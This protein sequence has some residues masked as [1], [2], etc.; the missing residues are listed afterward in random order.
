M[1]LS[2]SG[3]EQNVLGFTLCHIGMYTYTK[4]PNMEYNQGQVLPN[5]YEPP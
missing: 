5:G 1:S 4:A 2:V 3:K